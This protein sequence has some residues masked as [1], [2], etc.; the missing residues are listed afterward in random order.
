MKLTL[1]ILIVII[2]NSINILSNE[3]YEGKLFLKNSIIIEAEQITISNDTIFYKDLESSNRYNIATN[4]L[5]KLE[6]LEGNYKTLGLISGGFIGFTT[7]YLLS[8]NNLISYNGFDTK[9][10]VVCSVFGLVLGGI[11]GE[12]SSRKKDIFF[13]KQFSLNINYRSNPIFH[14]NT[15][16]YHSFT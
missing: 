8:N 6:V 2:F 14:S 16:P 15:Q 11:I 5:N 9:D 1:L 4:E 10:A 3:I 7:Y 13:R 12:F